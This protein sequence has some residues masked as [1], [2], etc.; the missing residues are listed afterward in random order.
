MA[1]STFH[2]TQDM[3]LPIGT[4]YYRFLPHPYF[5]DDRQEVFVLEGGEAFVYRI[6][7]MGDK[8]DYALKVMKPAFR[9]SSTLQITRY[10]AQHM[11][12]PGLFLA[13]RLCLTQEQYPE[14]IRRFPDLEYA[15]LMPWIEGRTWAG[16]MLDPVASVQYTPSNARKLAAA[17]AYVLWNLEGR[18]LA[19]TDIAGGNVLLS[20]DMRQ[21]QLID[22]DSLY[23]PGTKMP[24]KRSRGSPGYQHPKQD[25]RGQWRPDGDRFAGA[26]LLT[27]MLTWWNPVVRAETPEGSESLFTPQELQRQDFPRWRRIRRTLE[28]MN[29]AL[30]DLFDQAWHAQKIEDCPDFS[31]WSMWMGTS[32][33]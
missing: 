9:D 6:Q 3:L 27:E 15:V 8:Q 33:V 31:T 10:L 11:N 23:I 24:K 14:L 25:E 7:H 32:F 2:P 5:S 13:R 20:P 4:A 19:H 1:V 18:S 22:L 30:R 21:I 16:L 12:T 28:Q 29:P 17:M 26:I